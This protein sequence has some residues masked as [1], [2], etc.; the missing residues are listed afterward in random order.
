MVWLLL[1]SLLDVVGDRS[2]LDRDLDENS[3][4]FSV[5]DRNGY[6]D[7]H[8]LASSVKK[9]RRISVASIDDIRSRKE[10]EN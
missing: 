9:D 2:Q 7:R 3:Q 10:A 4:I 1:Y 5:V 6:V 8:P